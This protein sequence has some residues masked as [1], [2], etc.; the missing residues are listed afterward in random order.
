MGCRRKSRMVKIGH[1]F[2]NIPG[3]LLKISVLQRSKFVKNF[4][5]NRQNPKD[6]IFTTPLTWPYFRPNEKLGRGEL[7]L[8]LKLRI[9]TTIAF[10]VSVC[11]MGLLNG[12]CWFVFLNVHC[13]SFYG[14]RS[15]KDLL[16]FFSL[17]ISFA[18]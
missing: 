2:I 7:F 13:I 11:E 4:I 17:I 1:I 5:F 18:D 8:E 15:S 14:I 9:A 10:T 3:I 16:A 12:F 6:M